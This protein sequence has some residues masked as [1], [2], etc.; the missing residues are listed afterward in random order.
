[1]F[2]YGRYGDLCVVSELQHQWQLSNL[3]DA[4]CSRKNISNLVLMILYLSGHNYLK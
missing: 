1:V 4:Y 2:D 3:M